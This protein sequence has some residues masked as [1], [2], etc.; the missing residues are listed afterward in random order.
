MPSPVALTDAQMMAIL[1][2][3]SAQRGFST[4]WDLYSSAHATQV[5]LR[6]RLA[7]VLVDTDD[8]KTMHCPML[9]VPRWWDSGTVRH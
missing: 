8:T 1:A 9:R 3:A 2:A 6:E 7:R 4:L 5:R